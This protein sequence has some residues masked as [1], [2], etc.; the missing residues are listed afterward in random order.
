MRVQE[1]NQKDSEEETDQEKEPTDE[2]VS[3]DK[4]LVQE[5]E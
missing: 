1:K 3:T 4:I 5:V 2:E